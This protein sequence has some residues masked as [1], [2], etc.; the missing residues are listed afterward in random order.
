MM[1]KMIGII[2][3]LSI[4]RTGKLPVNENEDQ[5]K[6]KGER[7]QQNLFGI[8]W[9]GNKI[10]PHDKTRN[11]TALTFNDLEINKRKNAEKRQIKDTWK[12]FYE[13]LTH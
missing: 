8:Q 6:E 11:L 2:P 13:N 4:E 1:I 5:F 7:L 12:P 3:I 9:I 10:D